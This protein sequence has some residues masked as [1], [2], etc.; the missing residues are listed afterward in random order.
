M[1][2]LVKKNLLGC[3]TLLPIEAV[4]YGAGSVAGLQAS[5]ASS[6]V[7]RALLITGNTIATRTDLVERVKVAAGGRIAGVFHETIQHVSRESVLR[8]AEQ[9]REMTA[10]G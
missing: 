2:E 4:H 3:F 7:Q 1:P 10:C 6:G 9:A 8:A 5:L